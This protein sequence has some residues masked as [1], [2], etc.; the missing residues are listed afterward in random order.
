MALQCGP[1]AGLHAE[2]G[3]LDEELQ[4]GAGLW[5]AGGGLEAGSLQ[6]SVHLRQPQHQ[7]GQL[8][9]LLLH[10]PACGPQPHHNAASGA[11]LGYPSRQ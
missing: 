2:G 1:G 6:Q 3:Y 10:G 8:R 11:L 5:P 4:G 7:P 9:Q